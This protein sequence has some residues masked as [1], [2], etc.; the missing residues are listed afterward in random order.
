MVITLLIFPPLA[1]MLLCC[2]VFPKR[3]FGLPTVLANVVT[4]CRFLNNS[5]KTSQVPLGCSWQSS[6]SMFTMFGKLD[7]SQKGLEASW[8]HK[9]VVPGAR[10]MNLPQVVALTVDIRRNKKINKRK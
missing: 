7:S 1:L 10:S 2:L 6:H 9:F 5:S 4:A 8:K 3:L